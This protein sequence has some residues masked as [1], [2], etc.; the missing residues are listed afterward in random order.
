M[1][2]NVRPQ[3]SISAGQQTLPHSAH[4]SLPHHYA[5]YGLTL[6]S[7]IEL[8]ALDA[9]K[10]AGIITPDVRVTTGSLAPDLQALIQHHTSPYYT[11]P[12]EAAG[13]PAHLVVSTLQDGRYYHFA[14]A[15]G[16]QFLLDTDTSGIWCGWT[17]SLTVQEIA[18]YLLG[19]VIGFMLRVR[20]ATCLHA[21]GVLVEGNAL[22]I[23]GASG[24]GKSTL[25]AAFA[26]A[27]YPVLTDDILPL[28][29]NAGQI[30][31]HS[32]YSRLRL[33]PNSF[34]NLAELPDE[35]PALAPGWDKC[36]LDLPANNYQLHT[37]S[38]PLKTVYMVDWESSER[39]A[40]AILPVRESA[41]VALL[42]TN[43][44]RN[45]LLNPAMREQEFFLL[46]TLAAS[47]TV[48]RLCP[49]DDITA[50]SGLRDLLL[51]DFET[52]VQKG[53]VSDARTEHNALR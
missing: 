29:S 33:Y 1:A 50:I 46:A 44:Y 16:A 48:R 53:L 37:S 32:G 25:A 38:A 19:P 12:G 7:D 45:E 49:V 8:P 20:G 11:E 42:A 28:T 41:A 52:I 5:V 2:H 30:Y 6:A 22:A 36:Y 23:T 24:V 47:V 4:T 10:I 35:L 21:S 27:G 15:A 31:T 26:A 9:E 40:P 34:K 17:A 39:T 51:A 14:Y 13:D 18:L 3:G 43:T